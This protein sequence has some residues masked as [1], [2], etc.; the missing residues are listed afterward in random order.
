YIHFYDS[1]KNLKLLELFPLVYF[2]ARI[3]TFTSFLLFGNVCQD[4]LPE[5]FRFL[6]RLCS[7]S[8]SPLQCDIFPSLA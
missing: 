7:S 4:Q 3:W 6:A 5:D 8:V 1:K 2:V